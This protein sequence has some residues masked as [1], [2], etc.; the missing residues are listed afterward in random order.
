M[1][2]YYLH[3][4]ILFTTYLGVSLMDYNGTYFQTDMPR[5]ELFIRITILCVISELEQKIQPWKYECN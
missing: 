3:L 1:L 5:V 4:G 2:L